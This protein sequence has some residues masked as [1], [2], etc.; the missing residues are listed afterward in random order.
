MAMRGIKVGMQRMRGIR[1]RMR[2]IRVAMM[3]TR[4]RMR[5]IRVGTRGIKVGMIAIRVGMRGIPGIKVRMWDTGY[6]N[7][8]NKGENLRIGVELMNYNC[9]EGQ[10]TRI[11]V[12]LVTV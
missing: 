2:E 12:F 9:G 4:V 5:G 10:E 8:R 3:K 11:C 6:G 7:E 1:V